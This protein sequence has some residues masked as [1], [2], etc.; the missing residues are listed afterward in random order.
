MSHFGNGNLPQRRT[1]EEGRRV[2]RDE[3]ALSSGLRL[4]GDRIPR[5]GPYRVLKHVLYTDL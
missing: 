3:L 2:A 1:G 4:A 5:A